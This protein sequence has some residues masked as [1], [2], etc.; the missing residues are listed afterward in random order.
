M[1]WFK[2][3]SEGRSQSGLAFPSDELIAALGAG[4]TTSGESVD[5]TSAM[6]MADVFTAVNII[7]ELVGSLPFKVYRQVGDDNLPAEGHRA[8]NMLHTAPNPE[9]PAHRFWS[10]LTAH[11]LL[12]GNAFVEK[13]RDADGLVSELWL[14]HPSW[15]TV[16][17]S[18]ALR[19]KRYLVDIPNVGRQTYDSDR[20]LHVFGLSTDGL[21]GLSPIGQC[22]E[23]LGIAKSRER[24]EADVYA[25]RPFLGGW[26]EHPSKLNDPVSLGQSWTAIY[27]GQGKDRFGTPVLEEGAEFKTYQAPLADMQFVDAMQ[28]SK[29]TI[30][31]IFKLPPWYLGGSVGNSLTYQT[32]EGNQLQLARHTLAPLTTCI[33]DFVS[34]D[35]GIF[36]FSSWSGK[37]DLGGLMRGDSKARTD[38]YTAMDKIGAI[39]TDE[40][41]ELEDMPPLTDAQRRAQ[42]EEAEEAALAN[43]PAPTDQPPGLPAL[44]TGG[45]L[46]A[47]MNGGTP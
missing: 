45:P 1:G 25:K 43:V 16:E 32:V 14:L 26:I 11:M 35:R 39:L 46:A 31:N 38:Y 12:W 15:V 7:S 28:M 9:Q 34:F 33:A 23:Q 30:A 6:R 3:R 4:A 17:W 37:F 44:P 13:M 41:R 8:Y 20:V 2:R 29:T 22:R 19:Q 40:I 47:G 18:Q 27:A 36:P 42:R 10:T 21:I 24:F 5:A